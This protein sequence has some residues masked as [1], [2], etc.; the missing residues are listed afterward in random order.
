MKNYKVLVG[1]YRQYSNK[2]NNFIIFNINSV[3]FN[4]ELK[5]KNIN[6]NLT[7]N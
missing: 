4:Q 1:K 3:V 5:N 6:V 2:T 7:N